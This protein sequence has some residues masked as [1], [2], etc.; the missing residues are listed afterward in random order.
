MSEK[1]QRLDIVT[2]EKKIFSE[3]IRF[4]VAPGSEG[5]LGVLPDHAALITALKIGL[6]RIEQEGKKFNIAVSGG[7]L[8][9][10]DSK[11]TVLAT[12]AERAEDID[13]DRA[14]AAKQRAEQR[15][16]SKT[17]DLDVLR[18]ELAL[19]RAI[20]RLKATGR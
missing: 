9:V 17:P 3:D 15:L 6:L 7:F 11:A 8:E 14:E 10:R 12:A 5:E 4:F 1:T 16:A 2:P 20:N 13:V 18:A 19:K